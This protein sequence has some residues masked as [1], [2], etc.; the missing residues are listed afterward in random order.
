MTDF[1]IKK[2]AHVSEY[3]ILYF[4]VFRANQ[5]KWLTSLFMVL[6]Y[7]ISDEI[8]QAFVPGR[9][10]KIYDALGFDLAGAIISAFVIW[11]IFQIHQ[12]KL[13]K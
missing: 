1:I 13:K 10:P 6:G 7:A 9:S 4:L 3:A 2:S 12:K 11:Y 8:H 5:K